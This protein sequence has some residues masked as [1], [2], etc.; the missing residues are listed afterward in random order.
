MA[1]R[2]APATSMCPQVTGPA[3]PGGNA[4]SCRGVLQ[5]WVGSGCPQCGVWPGPGI[6]GCVPI[7]GGV[8]PV[9]RNAEF[10][11]SRPRG[12]VAALLVE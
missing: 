2:A 4:P 7:V 10:V 9:V 12:F 3:P 11:V 6:R 1:A 8:G 5:W